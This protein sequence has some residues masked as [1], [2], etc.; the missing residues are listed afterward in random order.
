MAGAL[1]HA[2]IPFWDAWVIGVPAP[3]RPTWEAFG[4][5]GTV[6]SLDMG[7]YFSSRETSWPWLGRLV[8]CPSSRRSNWEVSLSEYTPTCLFYNLLGG[9]HTYETPVL[10]VDGGRCCTDQSSV[11]RSG[12]AE[13]LGVYQASP[14]PHLPPS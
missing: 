5:R 14:A 10:Q 6:G 12:V 11:S 13:F 1:S 2:G 8:S 7:V 4:N 3:G 9:F